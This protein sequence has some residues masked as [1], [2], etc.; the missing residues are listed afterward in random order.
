MAG[1]IERIVDGLVA[2]VARE[3]WEPDE[4]LSV[5][6]LWKK[7]CVNWKPTQSRVANHAEIDLISVSVRF[8]RWV[9]S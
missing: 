9:V 7:Q 4:P 1:H 2:C 3:G 6:S 8:K 5:D